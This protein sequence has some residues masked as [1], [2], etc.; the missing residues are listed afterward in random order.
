MLLLDL[1]ADGLEPKNIW[2]VVC[3]SLVNDKVYE[4]NWPSI[5]I[6][7]LKELIDEHDLIVAHNGIEF[8]FR[9]LAKLFGITIHLEKTRDT[10]VLS[11]L[12]NSK[13]E[14]G[15]SLKAWGIA[16]G[17]NK[18]EFDGDFSRWTRDMVDYC[19][20]DVEVLH[21][22]WIHLSK[23]LDRNPGVFDDAIRIEQHARWVARQMHDN[24]FYFDIDEA[25]RIYNEI[26][27]RV[28]ELAKLMEEAFPPKVEHIQL[29]T[30]IKTVVTPFNP[31][32]VKQIIDRMWEIGWQPTSKTKGHIEAEKEKD[33]VKLE[34]FKVYGW[35]IDEENMST[36][37]SDAPEASSFLVEYILLNARLRTL[38]EWRNSFNSETHRIHGEFNPLGTATHRMSH[39][40]PNMGNIATKKT[41]KYNSTR[42][43]D[44]A[45]YYG[46]RMRALWQAP[47]GS[48]LVGTD[49]EGAHLRIFAHL[50]DDPAFTKALIEGRKDDGSDAH[51]KNKSI[52][53][54][55]CVDRDRAKTFIFSYLNGAAAPKVSQI[56]GCSFKAAKEA[57]DTFVRNYPGLSLLKRTI[58]PK[59]AAQ[60]YYIGID[61]RYVICDSEHLMMGSTLQ[62][63]EATLMKNAIKM[64]MEEFDKIGLK[65]KIINIVHD[66]VIY[67]I[68]GSKED[69]E[70]AGQ[71]QAEAIKLAGEKFKLRCPMSGEFKVGKNWLQV[72]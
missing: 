28:T 18:Q 19:I 51:S 72:H 38:T 47:P 67:E 57:L 64:A 12:L 23:V 49:M 71:I 8:D 14:D 35:K 45:V 50:I 61:G 31:G 5:D 21:K 48:W 30:K 43:R 52:L 2:C 32:S 33:N 24:G 29:K 9:V 56:F 68:D 70:K 22:L 62:N 15:H 17:C 39:S 1:E 65:Y 66:E 63:T 40:K 59:A 13:R 11:Q 44:L 53:G 7:K 55:I 25:N 34:K 46:G 10:M 6:D 41:I 69:A 36:L 54:T 27:E 3:K 16:L 26:S 37:P 60:G 58:F 4:F 42:L 20:Q